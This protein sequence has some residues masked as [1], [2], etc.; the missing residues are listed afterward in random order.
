MPLTP[1]ILWFTGLPC[2]GKTTLSLAV[3]DALR[4]AGNPVVV[5]DGDDLRSGL[6]SDLGFSESDRRENIRRAAAMAALLNRQRFFVCCSFVSPSE[7]LR[8]LARHAGGKDHFVEIFVDTPLATCESRD[9]K[10]MYARARRGEIKQF[11]G[12]SAPF[13]IPE[14]PELV[15]RAGDWTVED[16][17]RRVIDFINGD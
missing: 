7:E 9:I 10:G 13:E 2:A 3:A 4:A 11:T 16:C 17:V 5:I 15:L 1:K 12:I 14:N 6:C 8:D